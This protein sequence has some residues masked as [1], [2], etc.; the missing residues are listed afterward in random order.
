MVWVPLGFKSP[1]GTCVYP[2]VYNSI[3]EYS[4]STP[5]YTQL[6]LENSYHN[7]NTHS[8]L[9]IMLFFLFFY[10]FYLLDY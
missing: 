5:V 7:H 1:D 2:V 8:I 10:F 9:N 3:E 4:S 6:Y